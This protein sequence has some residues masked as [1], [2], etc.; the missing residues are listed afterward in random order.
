M[1]LDGLVR[2][3]ARAVAVLRVGLGVAAL[4]SPG[5]AARLWVGPSAGEPAGVVLGRAAGV[6]DLA[7]GA[8][9]LLAARQGPQAER[10]WV[11]AGAA[12]DAVDVATTL[13]AWRTLA[14][15]R[16]LVTGAAVG[17]AALG[18]LASWSTPSAAP[19]PR[20]ER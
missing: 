3:G 1:E 2:T 9:V 20:V 14:A 11:A 7:L 15:G 13:A 4:V 12:C 8:G 19:P 10:T 6:R 17:A 16:L 18:A 5:L